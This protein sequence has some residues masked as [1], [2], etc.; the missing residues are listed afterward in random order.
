LEP[1]VYIA[2]DEDC[3]TVRST[4]QD[5]VRGETGASGDLGLIDMC[6]RTTRNG[7][8]GRDPLAVTAGDLRELRERIDS[9]A[10]SLVRATI[11]LDSISGLL[12]KN[13]YGATV[14]FLQTLKEVVQRTGA[15]AFLTMSPESHHEA[16]LDAVKPLFDASI[17][18]GEDGVDPKTS[19]LW[20]LVVEATQPITSKNASPPQPRS[21]SHEDFLGE[22]SRAIQ[23][24]TEKAL[25]QTGAEALLTTLQLGRFSAEPKTFH[26]ALF[27]ALG[28]GALTVEKRIVRELFRRLDSYHE[29]TPDFDFEKYVRVAWDSY[30]LRSGEPSASPA[31]V[32]RTIVE[33]A[34]GS[35]STPQKQG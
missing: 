28:R 2:T 5:L 3:E 19:S 1:V 33:G 15:V 8:T 34:I 18:I 12:L 6:S 23:I 21:P 11:L 16:F 26:K 29:E 27:S 22:L 9:F 32:D 20:G 10:A 14:E 30:V 25:G 35:A 31:R 7:P 13:D 24:G 17:R 4:L